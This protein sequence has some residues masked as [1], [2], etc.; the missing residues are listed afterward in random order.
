MTKFASFD[1]EGVVLP[2]S[3]REL[4]DVIVAC[5]VIVSCELS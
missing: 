1:D 4:F 3:R 2:R 5:R